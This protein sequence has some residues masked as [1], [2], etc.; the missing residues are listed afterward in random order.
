MDQDPFGMTTRDIAGGYE[1]QQ[2]EDGETYYLIGSSDISSDAYGAIE[3]TVGKIGWNDKF[4]LVW[5]KE[6]GSGRG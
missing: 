3:G 5:Q 2:W 6:C 1:L 4:I